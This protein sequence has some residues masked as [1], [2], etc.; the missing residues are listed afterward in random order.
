[1]FYFSCIIDSRTACKK[2]SIICSKKQRNREGRVNYL[3]TYHYATLVI[4]HRSCMYH[5]TKKTRYIYSESNIYYMLPIIISRL[6]S[7]LF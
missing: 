6:L 2:K 4:Y 3:F 5:D 1:M 7:M